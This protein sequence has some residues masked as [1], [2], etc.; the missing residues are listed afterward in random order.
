VGALG[1]P[2]ELGSARAC[3]RGRREKEGGKKIKKKGEGKRKGEREKGRGGGGI[4]GGDRGRSSTHAG[5][6]HA[7][8]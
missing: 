3:E 2:H 1:V 6:R 4:R 5:R 8:H 7:A